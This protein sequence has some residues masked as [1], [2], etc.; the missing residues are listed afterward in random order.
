MK[1]Q[2]VFTKICKKRSN[3]KIS[4]HHGPVD[5]QLKLPAEE[6]LMLMTHDL[7]RWFLIFPAIQ[8]KKVLKFVCYNI[9]YCDNFHYRDNF[10]DFDD[11]A[12]VFMTSTKMRQ[13]SLFLYEQSSR[14][15][16]YFTRT[17][18]EH[19]HRIYIE[20]TKKN[21]RTKDAIIPA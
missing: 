6:L 4:P 10:N 7:R 16:I 13:F 21:K 19:E 2:L 17:N 20:T 14:L 12:T 8:Q 9:N 5:L 11:T 18:T 1:L 15:K 3:F